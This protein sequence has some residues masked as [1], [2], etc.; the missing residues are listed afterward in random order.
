MGT[1]TWSKLI[2]D[3][4]T[5]A[6][7]LES[8][9]SLGALQDLTNLRAEKS[10]VSFN[11]SQRAVIS[12]VLDLPFGKGKKFLNR[13]SGPVDKVV[14][15]WGLNGFTTLQSGFPIALS[16]Q[17][18]ILQKSFGAGT[19]RPNVVAGC[20]KTTT[21]TEQAR[22][23]AWFNTACFTQPGSF[24]FGTEARTDPNLT[25]QGIANWEFSVFKDIPITER[26]HMQFRS[27]FFNIFNRTQFSNPGAQ[28][29]TASTYGIVTAQRNFPRQAQFA[30]RA[31][32]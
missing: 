3:S 2:G 32:F 1:Y 21:G 30:L 24:A 16:A 26:I 29:G 17:A 9:G 31:T 15:G 18:S 4:D 7:F 12:Y 5:L 22:L 20:D 13:I 6:S 25:S 8:S 11:V 23:N 10:L 28:V 14:S 19:T 27:K